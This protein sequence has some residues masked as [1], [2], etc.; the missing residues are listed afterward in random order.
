MVKAL[1][2]KRRC[3][4]VVKAL[5]LRKVRQASHSLRDLMPRPKG[6]LL[7]PVSA[8]CGRAAG[9]SGYILKGVV[10]FGRGL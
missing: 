10:G 9:Q 8:R 7:R 2:K 3:G 6:F 1:L 5:A 4:R